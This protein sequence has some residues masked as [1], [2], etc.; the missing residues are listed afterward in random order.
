MQ[1]VTNEYLMDEVLKSKC[2]VR[3]FSGSGRTCQVRTYWKHRRKAGSREGK[4]ACD[5]QIENKGETAGQTKTR[6]LSVESTWNEKIQIPN[7]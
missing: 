3:L 1:N 7:Y 6:K 5:I 2:G 4:G